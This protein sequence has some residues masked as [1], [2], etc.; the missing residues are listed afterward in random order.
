MSWKLKLLFPV[1]AA[2]A[3]APEPARAH[4]DTLDGPVVKA[5]RTALDGGKIEPVLAWVRPDDEAEI[6]DAF[7]RAR[8]VRATGKESRELA[9]RWFFET[10]VRV[11]RAAEGAPYTGLKPAGGPVDPA[12][13]AADAVVAGGDPKKLESLLVGAVKDGLRDH[14]ARLKAESPP[15]KDV[16][17]GRRWVAAYVPFVHW[18]EG[19]YASATKGPGHGEGHGGPGATPAGHGGPEEHAER[20]AAPAPPK[21]HGH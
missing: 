20:D 9:D 10:L 1:I 3:L 19:V 8:A 16:E 6:R 11:H 21:G 17:A 4:C 15:A 5:A 13:A 2:A 7:A 12:V 18:A 14:A